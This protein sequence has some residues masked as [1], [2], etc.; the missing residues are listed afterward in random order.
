MWVLLWAAGILSAPEI[1]LGQALV[2]GS[3]RKLDAG[4]DFEDPGWDYRPNL[5]KASHNLDKRG[6][7]PTGASKNGR[8]FEPVL[9]GQPDSVRRVPTPPGGLEGSAGALEISTVQSGIPGAPSR[10]PQQDDLIA[11]TVSRVGSLS[12]GRSPSVVTRVYVPPFE[13]WEQRTGNSFGYRASVVGRRERRYTKEKRGPE[14]DTYWPGMF[15]HLYR[16]DGKRVKETFAQIL[17]RSDERG[18]DFGGPRIAGPGWWTLGMSF[19]PD[20][21]VHYF[22][23]PGIENLTEND[24]IASHFPYQFRAQR[25]ETF[26]FDVVNQ[27]DGRTES[28][29]WI[30]DDPSVYAVR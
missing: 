13:E 22:A 20:G 10:T 25:V 7:L 26:F 19:T 11:A 16:A 23:R 4:D 24:R 27:D 18:V 6:R 9:R 8:W 14:T 28:T 5:P 21:R 12:V 29:K 1:G 2:P 3:G 15:F 30:V 17:V